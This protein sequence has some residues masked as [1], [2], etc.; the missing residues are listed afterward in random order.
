MTVSTVLENANS[1]ADLGREVREFG[2]SK[3]SNGAR[4]TLRLC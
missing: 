2:T 4:H 1:V 3:S